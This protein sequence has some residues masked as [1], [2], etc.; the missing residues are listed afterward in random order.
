MGRSQGYVQKGLQDVCTSTIVAT[1]E[2]LPSTP[3]TS[4]AI[5]SPKNKEENPM[6]PK[7]SNERIIQ[8]GYPSD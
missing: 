8:M 5:K 2:T 4:S 6:M 7:P 1:S 3:L